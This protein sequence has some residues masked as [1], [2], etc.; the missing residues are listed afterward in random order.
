MKALRA[1]L[2]LLALLASTCQAAQH[3]TTARIALG[4]G[5][6]EVEVELA[7]TAQQRAQGLM[8]RSILAAHHGMLFIYPDQAPRGVWM[9]NTR[10]ALDVVFLDRAQQVVAL[11][12]HLPP[13]PADPC[14]I[15]RSTVAAAYMLELPAGSIKQYGLAVGE[16]LSLPTTTP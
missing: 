1:T 8:Y 6:P 7:E 3:L 15:Y 12:P 2:A 10:L 16:W 11:L 5:R 9:K 4:K 14:P 13:C